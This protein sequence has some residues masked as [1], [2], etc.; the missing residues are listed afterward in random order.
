MTRRGTGFGAGSCGELIQGVTSDDVAFQVSMPIDIGTAVDV[1]IGDAEATDIVGLPATMQKTRAA[2]ERTLELLD[3]PPSRI[4][5][6]RHTRLPTG[7]G[8]GSSTADI[9]AAA[10]ATAHALGHH[11]TPDELACLAGS[12]EPSDGAMYERMTV[13]RRRGPALRTLAWAPTFTAVMLVPPA[14]LATEAAD[15]RALGDARHEYDTLLAQLE[16]A[17]ARRDP[18]PFA[19]AAAASA[20]LHHELAGNTWVTHIDATA[21]AAGARGWNIAHTGTVAGLWFEPTSRGRRAARDAAARLA[22]QFPGMQ[23]LTATA[24]L[25]PAAPTK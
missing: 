19:T 18:R 20:R 11:L 21:G 12:I 13:A 16:Q 25:A 1:A 9:V 6:R 15:I 23:T 14:T 24:G 8:M 17:T 7:K 4:D 3:A 5:V 22:A 2:I 10:R